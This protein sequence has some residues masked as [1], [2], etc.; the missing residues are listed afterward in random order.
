MFTFTA[1]DIGE[2]S[3]EEYTTLRVSP[4]PVV[5]MPDP[6]KVKRFAHRQLSSEDVTCL[7]VPPRA[8]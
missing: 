5:E 6:A 7:R 2:I 3:Q 8:D 4:A 1:A